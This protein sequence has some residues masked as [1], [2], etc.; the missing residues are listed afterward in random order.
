M[1]D[2]EIKKT[3]DKAEMVAH[4]ESLL[5]QHGDHFRALDWENQE[6]QE[7]RY[8]ILL[9]LPIYACRTKN[10]SVLDVGAGLGDLYRFLKEKGWLEKL[11]VKYTGLDISQA[12]VKMARQKFPEGN[13]KVQ[14]IFE[15][16]LSENYDFVVGSGIFNTRVSDSPD[17]QIFV[18]KIIRKMFE[19]SRFGAAVNFQSLLVLEKLPLE[20]IQES[21][22][23][24]YYYDPVEMLDFA[25][26]VTKRF[27]LRHDYHP[28]DFTLFLIKNFGEG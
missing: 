27:I 14:D 19:I 26:A 20:R 16:N 17:Y 10:F 1:T 9:H 6:A 21:F 28:A 5:A 8:S 13:F 4:F 7:L 18:R 2:N 3:P 23:H 11:N 24:Y 12:M 15:E 22:K 25:R